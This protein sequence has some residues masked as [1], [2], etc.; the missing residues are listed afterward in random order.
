MWLNICGRFYKINT[1]VKYKHTNDL[2]LI[3]N[4]IYLI[5]FKT[6]QNRNSI[7]DYFFLIQITNYKKNLLLY[8]N[9]LFKY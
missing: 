5:G 7:F 3:F 4:Q 8:S 6:L 2:K 1:H 9:V